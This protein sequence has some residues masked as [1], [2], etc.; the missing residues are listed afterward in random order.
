MLRAAIWVNIKLN[1]SHIIGVRINF[2]IPG[3]GD[4][5]HKVPTVGKNRIDTQ[6][7][8]HDLKEVVLMV[9]EEAHTKQYVM[10]LN[11]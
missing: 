3:L 2:V 5:K 4:I 7:E 9:Y 11:L 10:N 1:M 8:S 6:Y